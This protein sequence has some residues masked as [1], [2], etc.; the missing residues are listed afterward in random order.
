M[1]HK[2]EVPV[3]GVIENMSFFVCPS[4]G[5]RHE[6]FA[7]GGAEAKAAEWGLPFL[8]ALPIHP[9][10]RAAGDAGRPVLVDAPRSP[11]AEAFRT[12]A[13]RM[14]AQLSIQSRTGAAVAVPS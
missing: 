14:A 2:L 3:L 10:V 12:A 8:G 6:I 5:T 1:F 9:E 13:R 7:S 4:C 11:A